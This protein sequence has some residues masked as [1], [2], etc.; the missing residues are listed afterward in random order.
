MNVK[1]IMRIL[2][3]GKVCVMEKMKEG[4]IE[5]KGDTMEGST[6]EALPFSNVDY[7]TWYQ[8]KAGLSAPCCQIARRIGGGRANCVQRAVTRSSVCPFY[9]SRQ[10]RTV[11]STL[12]G[13][14]NRADR[15]R[16]RCYVSPRCPPCSAC[17]E[18]ST[19]RG[20]TAGDDDS[21]SMTH[22]IYLGA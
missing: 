15:T 11:R 22:E 5:G 17:S 1:S 7:Q 6:P 16:F 13:P 20:L 21:H 8:N 2:V 3:R 12:E 10:R 14:L 9:R 4:E 19:F 18:C